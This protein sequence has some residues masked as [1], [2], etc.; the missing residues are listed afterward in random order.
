MLAIRYHNQNTSSGLYDLGLRHTLN[1]FRDPAFEYPV[2][3]EASGSK[4]D[5][6][7]YSPS[8]LNLAEDAK[9]GV[10]DA[11]AGLSDHFAL[12]QGFQLNLAAMLG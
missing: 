9:Y 8:T 10:V 1:P 7:F 3:R 6:I 4:V 5:H 2:T 11:S 12:R